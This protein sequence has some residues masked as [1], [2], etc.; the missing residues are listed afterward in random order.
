MSSKTAPALESVTNVCTS[1]EISET[2]VTT[3]AEAKGVDPLD[4]E[5]LY[6]VVDPDALNR[7]FA[8]ARRAESSSLELEFSV[9]GCQVVV[10]GDG[11][12]AVTP[13]TADGTHVVASCDA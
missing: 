4:L 5:P 12:V 7:M 13:T 8:S 2:V 9:A 10:H 1:D 3:V 6:A 11:E